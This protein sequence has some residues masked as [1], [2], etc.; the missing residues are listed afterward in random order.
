MKIA[1]QGYLFIITLMTGAFISGWCALYYLT[2]IF[3]ILALFVAY[4]FRNPPREIPQSQGAIVSPADGRVIKIER[5]LNERFSKEELMKISIFMSI[6][7]VHINRIPISGKVTEILYNPGK[8]FAANVDKSSDQN[9]QNAV[10]LETEDQKKIIFIQIAGL[11]ARRIVCNIN[12]GSSVLTGQRFGLI[13]FGSRVDLYLPLK[14]VIDIRLGQKVKGG[15]TI[16]GYL[17]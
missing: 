11:I 4:F 8:F 9:E 1:K 2:G 3:F 5:C 14:T 15:E 16:V 6:F 10:L 17:Q 13:C 12:K 7:N